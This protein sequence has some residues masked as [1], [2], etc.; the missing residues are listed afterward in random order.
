MVLGLAHHVHQQV[1]SNLIT[2]TEPVVEVQPCTWAVEEDV[3]L[4]NRLRRNGLEPRTALFLPNS[5][6][7][8]NVARDLDTAR[9]VAIL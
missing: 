9:L 7:V 3:A 1:L 8:Y 6:T 2:A 4:D 5:H